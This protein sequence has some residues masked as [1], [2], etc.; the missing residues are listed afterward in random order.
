MHPVTGGNPESPLLWTAKSAVALDA[1]DHPVSPAT[2]AALLKARAH[3]L[4]P[5]RKRLEGTQHP[6]RDAQFQHVATQ[7]TTWQRAG[8]P[9]ISV[10]A[11]RNLRQQG[12]PCE[13]GRHAKDW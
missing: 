9:V 2:V 11:Q 13:R 12:S 5:N 7:T 3:R 8:V 4:Q 1:A 6:E 10:D